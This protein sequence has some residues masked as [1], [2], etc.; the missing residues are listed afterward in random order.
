M[1][2]RNGPERACPQ[3]K[4]VLTGATGRLEGASVSPFGCMSRWEKVSVSVNRT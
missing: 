1:P 2:D 4:D 3:K